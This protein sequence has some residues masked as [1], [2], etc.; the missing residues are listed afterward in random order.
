MLE[1]EALAGAEGRKG[2]GESD[3]IIF[4]L[5]CIKIQKIKFGRHDLRLIRLHSSPLPLT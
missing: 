5:K 2:I 1:K 4:Q 3:V